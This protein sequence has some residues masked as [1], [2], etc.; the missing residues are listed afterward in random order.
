MPKP[1]YQ[2]DICHKIHATVE[3]AQQCEDSHHKVVEV[4]KVFYNQYDK[5]KYPEYIRVKLDNGKLVDFWRKP[6]SPL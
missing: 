5:P 6:G 4:V 1:L 2:C 3:Q